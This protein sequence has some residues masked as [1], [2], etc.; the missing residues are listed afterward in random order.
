MAA[1]PWA[2]PAVA[3]SVSPVTWIVLMVAVPLLVY[4]FVLLVRQD[5][6][7][8]HRPHPGPEEGGRSFGD[9]THW[10]GCGRPGS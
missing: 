3:V 8:R 7:R 1:L 9:T 4:S 2:V 6:H 5:R 10:G